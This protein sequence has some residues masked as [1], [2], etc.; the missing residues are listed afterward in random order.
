MAEQLDIRIKG[1]T[2]HPSD[3]DNANG[4]LDDCMNIENSYGEIRPVFEMKQVKAGLTKVMF[5]HSY[6]GIDYFFYLDGTIVKI[7]KKTGE[8][9][10]DETTQVQ[11]I[12]E[13]VTG[14]QTIGN[15]VIISTTARLIY[16][17]HK[18]GAYTVLGDQLPFPVIQPSLTNFNYKSFNSVACKAE[19]GDLPDIDAFIANMMLLP[20]MDMAKV[21]E[22]ANALIKTSSEKVIASIVKNVAIISAEG[23]FT[24]PF[25]VRYALRLYDGT[26]TKHSPPFLLN[27]STFKDKFKGIYI[28]ANKGGTGYSM[29]DVAMQIAREQLSY[30]ISPLSGIVTWADIVSSVDIFISYPEYTIDV[31]KEVK[32]FTPNS[33]AESVASLVNDYLHGLPYKSSDKIL[34]NLSGEGNFYLL[35]S[36]TLAEIATGGTRSAKTAGKIASI[37]QQERMTDDYESH[38]TLSAKGTFSYNNRLI[39]TGVKKKAFTGFYNNSITGVNNVEIYGTG[40][41]TPSTCSMY[42]F[43]PDTNATYINSNLGVIPLKRHP[44]L[45]GSYF[46]SDTLA[47]LTTQPGS[48][49]VVSTQ[50]I[51]DV[52]E[53]LYSSEVNN[54]F[55][56]RPSGINTMPGKVIGVATTAEPMSQGQFG[57]F[58]LYVF[59]DKGIWAMEIAQTGSYSAKQIVSREVCINPESI[60]Q[61]R[62]EIAFMTEKGLC[63]ISGKETERITEVLED[64]NYFLPNCNVENLLTYTGNEAFITKVNTEPKLSVYMQGAKAFYDMLND[65]IYLYN[66]SGLQSVAYSYIFNLTSKTWSK[67]EETFTGDCNAYPIIYTEKADG[68]YSPQLTKTGVR[69]VFFITRPIKYG[70][71]LF[72]IERLKMTAM[73]TATATPPAVYKNVIVLYASRDGKKYNIVANTETDILTMRGSGYK[74]YKIAFS[75]TMNYTDSIS[76]FT[77][78]YQPKLTN[79]LR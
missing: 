41:F 74:Y 58:P 51:E 8:D 46:I 64:Y 76:M 73:L 57:Q 68:L 39:L 20:G 53:K 50:L 14:V 77:A 27:P 44:S 25:F 45:N 17:L 63:V 37:V 55:L 21:T 54:P 33:N 13:I 30:S 3:K 52:T 60:V 10:T 47:P 31:A 36:L 18:N 48:P 67:T 9:W 59:T 78:Q 70:Q 49:A 16:L 69:K 79:K 62:K 75:G 2:R 66:P 23:Y 7:K 40:G 38:S 42:L 29:K 65:R 34:E 26:I 72:I 43:Y 1:I 5:V 22:I 32:S 6:P 28:S 4:D 12:S 19:F 15:T 61:L 71:M 24:F 11:L 35:E 56:F